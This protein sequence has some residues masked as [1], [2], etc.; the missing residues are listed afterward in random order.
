MTPTDST[1]SSTLLLMMGKKLSRP[2]TR[3]ESE[4]ARPTSCPVGIRSRLLGVHGLEV[5]VHGVAQVVLHLEG[6]PAA[7]VAAEVGEAEGG[8]GQAE[9]QHQPGPQG[10]VVG[11]DDPVDDLP[12]DQ[13]DDGLRHSAE[14]GAAERQQHVASVPHHVAPQPADPSGLGKPGGHWHNRGMAAAYRVVRQ[15]NYSRPPSNPGASSGIWSKSIPAEGSSSSSTSGRSS[16]RL[17]E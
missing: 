17:W 14:H 7:A 9:E 1:T 3:V 13:R 12:L 4:L 10:R 15:P 6:H 5:V 11:Q 8:A 16:T 2:W